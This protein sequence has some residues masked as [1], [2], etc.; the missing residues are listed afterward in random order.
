MRREIRRL[1]AA[2][3]LVLP[4]GL[5]AAPGVSRAG[6]TTDGKIRPAALFQSQVSLFTNA[7]FVAEGSTGGSSSS[8]TSDDVLPSKPHGGGDPWN[9]LGPR[10]LAQVEAGLIT[11]EEAV[12]GC[13]AQVAG[14]NAFLAP[15]ALVGL[16]LALRRRR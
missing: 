7:S 10:E 14:G 1:L 15:L 16:F 2:A 12:S 8:S 4:V 5:V 9:V 11:P 6:I 13:G 3:L